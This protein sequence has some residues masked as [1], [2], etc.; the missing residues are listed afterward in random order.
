M[1]NNPSSP[2]VANRPETPKSTLPEAPP[3]SLRPSAAEHDPGIPVATES[4]LTAIVYGDDE[5]SPSVQPAST[6]T[7]APGRA[8]ATQEKIQ[9]EEAQRHE[10]DHQEF[11]AGEEV[12]QDVDDTGSPS[13]GRR[14]SH[15]R[16]DLISNMYRELEVAGEDELVAWLGQDFVVSAYIELAQD[17]LE[18]QLTVDLAFLASNGS[19][20]RSQKGKLAHSKKISY[21]VDVIT[22][23]S[24]RYLP[25][26]VDKTGWSEDDHDIRFISL[27]V[28]GAVLPG[29]C[30]AEEFPRHLRKLCERAF[31]LMH[32]IRWMYKV[33]IGSSAEMKAA[34]KRKAHWLSQL[35]HLRKQHIRQIGDPDNTAQPMQPPQLNPLPIHQSPEVERV[36]LSS[37]S[38]DL[39]APIEGHEQLSGEERDCSR[40]VERNSIDDAAEHG[41]EAATS[42]QPQSPEL[43]CISQTIES[44]KALQPSRSKLMTDLIQLMTSMRT[45]SQGEISELAQVIRSVQTDSSTSHEM[46]TRLLDSTHADGPKQLGDIVQLVRSTSPPHEVPDPDAA[47]MPPS[48]NTSASKDEQTAILHIAPSTTDVP[49]QSSAGQNPHPQA[50]GMPRSRH[51]DQQKAVDWLRGTARDAFLESHKARLAQWGLTPEHEGTCL[52][53]GA[54]WDSLD[55]MEILNTFLVDDCPRSEDTERR[56]KFNL[57][58]HSPLYG[59]AIAWFLGR[60]PRRGVDLD[61]FLSGQDGPWQQLHGSHRCHHGY[62]IIA[63]HLLYE[64]KERNFFRNTCKFGARKLRIYSKVFRSILPNFQ[65]PKYCIEHDPP[66]LLQ[67]AALTS[68]EAILIQ[69]AVLR[70][71]R[72]LPPAGPVPRPADFEPKF[73]TFEYQLPIQFGAPDIKVHPDHLAYSI[74][75]ATRDEMEWRCTFCHNARRRWGKITGLWAHLKSHHHDTKSKEER[76]EHVKRSTGEY[77]ESI[78]SRRREGEYARNNPQVWNKLLQANAPTFTWEVFSH[79]PLQEDRFFENVQASSDN[80]PLDDAYL[81]KLLT[82]S[83][84]SDGG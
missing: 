69:F 27:I 52:L 49:E 25:I 68:V 28:R 55:P 7:K 82:E 34:R 57:F 42:G 18:P 16:V 81:N 59:R 15:M 4:G 9:S 37:D 43:E 44:L 14:Y 72:S 39:V 32:W 83:G 24:E 67:H 53:V 64:D 26:Q 23:H 35:R 80:D 79:W 54:D 63:N 50:Y 71:A 77:L 56:L 13:P 10:E 61:Q 12:V 78:R 41:V 51:H 76:L 84:T 6:R 29:G 66:C 2:A 22:L 30:W 75:S 45:S 33:S 38:E 74:K 47:S 19:V 8:Y 20:P 73:D 40:E 48:S 60:W 31:Y 5:A 17:C 58:D 21:V 36:S 11:E 1:T 3:R 62:C 70:Q 46:I 65:L